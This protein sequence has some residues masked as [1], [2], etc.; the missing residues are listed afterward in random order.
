MKI[1]FHLDVEGWIERIPDG[2]IRLI[3]LLIVVAP[4]LAVSGWFYF[5][6][7]LP[8]QSQSRYSTLPADVSMGRTVVSPQA[9]EN[10]PA[11]AGVSSANAM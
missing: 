7:N 3:G 11:T 8:E 4:V 2:V 6:G 10:D 5:A 9:Y 1:A